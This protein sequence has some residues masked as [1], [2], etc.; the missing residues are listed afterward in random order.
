MEEYYIGQ[1]FEGAYPPEAA[2]WCNE[3]GGCYIE[4]IEPDNDIKRFEIKKVPALTPEQE[5]ARI[6]NLTCTKREFALILGQMGISYAQLKSLISEN[7]NAQL[8]W[9]LCTELLRKNPLLDIM[10]AK[11]DIKP[12]QIDSIFRYAN[13]EIEEL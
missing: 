2:M 12:E 1:I 9:D 8:E 3:L 7:D 11:L 5:K 10:A 13:G 4:E 6:G